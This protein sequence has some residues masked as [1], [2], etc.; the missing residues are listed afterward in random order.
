MD[1]DVRYRA[2][3]VDAGPLP[4]RQVSL[5]A[6]LDHGL[7]TIDPLALTLPQGAISGSVRL[8]ARNATPVTS[9]NLALAHAQL[10]EVLPRVQG[11]PAAEGALAA[12]RGSP[13]PA[14]VGARGG[15]QR[16]RRG[17]RSPSRVDRCASCSPS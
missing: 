5:H 6:R 9:I 15:G 17:R 16:Q 3:T 13:A 10:Q 2:E 1:A 14:V 7:L 12:R 8:D 11:Q 4:I